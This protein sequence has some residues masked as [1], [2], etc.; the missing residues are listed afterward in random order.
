MEELK[1]GST[2]E[3]VKWLQ[4]RL[5]ELGYGNCLVGDKPKKLT[6]DG[7]FGII[8]ETALSSFQAKVI[9]GLTENF[10]NDNVPEQYRKD[11]I[12]DGVLNYADWYV[13]E[14][15]EKLKEWY[16]I[17][18]E[19]PVIEEPKVI[20]EPKTET[21]QQKIINE[22]IRLAKGEIGVVEHGGNNY[23]KRVQEYQYIGSNG[24]MGGGAAWC[25]Y[26]QNW[27]QVTACKNL[28]LKYKG[29]Y[30]GYTPTVTNW[31]I[32]NGIG[33]KHPKMSQ[34]DIGDMGYVYSRVRNN[35]QHVFLIIGKTGNNVI[36][37][38]GN[39]NPGGSSS[40]FGVFKRQR[41]LGNQ[42]W[43]VVKWWKLYK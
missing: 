25:Q 24:A 31:G 39:T 43:A 35:S 2:G 7:K 14:N 37:I 29:T 41:P 16:K 18:I 21:T 15:F 5:I 20:I 4:K 26:Y 3:E 36:T 12:V 40:G 13:L 9:D 38:E 22:V 30:S 32:K 11:C 23:G 19:K 6:V 33:I 28:N 8:T 27:L 1:Y 42:C 10:I 17:E 34:I